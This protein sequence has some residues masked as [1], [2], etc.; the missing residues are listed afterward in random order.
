MSSNCGTG[1]R[2]HRFT[3]T[4]VLTTVSAVSPP[5]KALVPYP[6]PTA[7]VGESS[8]PTQKATDIAS[9]RAGLNLIRAVQEMI[10]MARLPIG[11]ELFRATVRMVKLINRLA[12]NDRV[13]QAL[14]NMFDDEPT[15]VMNA[16]IN[17]M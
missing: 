1:G 9:R 13:V 6:L 2:V 7:G 3:L 8:R 5:C 16:G 4:T 11:L 10:S 17:L 12:K 15:V 14:K